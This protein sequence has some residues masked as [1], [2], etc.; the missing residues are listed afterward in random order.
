MKI[1]ELCDRQ[2]FLG[3]L[4]DVW[5]KSVRATHLFLTDDEILKLKEYVPTAL[6]GVSHLIIAE[7]DGAP[8]AFMGT[9]KQRLEMLFILPEY[10][11]MGLGACLVRLGIEKYGIR[12]VGVNEQNPGAIGF[13]RHMGFETFKRSETD[14]EGNPYPILYM[15][16]QGQ[17]KQN[18]A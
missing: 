3:S 4:T 1:Y 14:G 2:P 15:R 8:V 17:I 18:D 9:D 11:G 16:L 6:C 10:R 5:E 13:Y 12:E 7:S